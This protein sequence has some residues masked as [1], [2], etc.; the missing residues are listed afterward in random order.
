MTEIEEFYVIAENGTC[1]FARTN[2]RDKCEGD[3]VAGFLNAINL[4]SAHITSDTIQVFR[5]GT[6]QSILYSEHNMLFVALVPKSAH[7]K[8]IRKK[9]E[10][11]A[12]KFF[13]MY[14]PE[15]MTL[16]WRGNLDI[17]AGLNEPFTKFIADP[18]A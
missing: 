6:C 9:L 17:F 13:E 16:K 2:A 10:L 3:L 14:S 11:F 8:T 7:I 5:F 4:L 15:Y 12:G 18:H 1:V